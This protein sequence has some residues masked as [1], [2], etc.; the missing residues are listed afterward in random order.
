[1]IEIVAAHTPRHLPSVVALF[2]EYEA[3]LDFSLC[4]QDFEREVAELPGRYAPPPGR[5]LLGFVQGRALGCVAM[6]KLDAAACEMKRLYVR[7]EARGTGLGRR[8]AEQIVIEARECGYGTMRLDTVSTM[9]AA[10]ALYRSLGF[11]ETEPYCDNP[12]AGVLYFE[13]ALRR[14][15]GDP[16]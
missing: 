13:L 14:A 16:L 9:R 11:R 12:I 5:L 10:I 6:R 2:R 7:P 15:H 8:L 4:F 3:S 1:V